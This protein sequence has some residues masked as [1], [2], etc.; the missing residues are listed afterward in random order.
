MNRPAPA[1]PALPA[2]RSLPILGG[3][4]FVAFATLLSWPQRGTVL[5]AVGLACLLV[6]ACLLW[7]IRAAWRHHTHQQA[8][9]G[10][11]VE[12]IT[13]GRNRRTGGMVAI[14]DHGQVHG[15]D[16]HGERMPSMPVTHTR[17]TAPD[18]LAGLFGDE[19]PTA[20]PPV[21]AGDTDRVDQLEADVRL[22]AADLQHLAGLVDRNHTALADLIL[23]TRE[24]HSHG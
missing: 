21:A 18:A 17:A 16:E 8:V 13:V 2:S 3:T 4:G 24:E 14:D 7:A 10:R 19:Q 22:V 1:I 23:S 20:A 9:A 11:P 6:A 5:R 12:T 15:V